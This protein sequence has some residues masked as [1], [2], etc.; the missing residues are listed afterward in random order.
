MRT[1]LLAAVLSAAA[2][3]SLAGR[4]TVDPNTGPAQEARAQAPDERLDQKVTCRVGRARL[5]VLLEDITRQTGVVVRAG[6]HPG[7]WQVRDIPMVVYVADVPLGRLLRAV[8]DASHCTL[9]SE[10]VENDAKT[11]TYRILRPAAARNEIAAAVEQ[12]R[13]AQ[14]AALKWEWDALVRIAGLPEQQLA[15]GVKPEAM[16]LLLE[17]AALAA[18]LAPDIRQRVFSGEVVRLDGLESPQ[19]RDWFIRQQHRRLDSVPHSDTPGRAAHRQDLKNVDDAETLT[20]TMFL[21]DDDAGEPRV[22]GCVRA[23]FAGGYDESYDLYLFGR[24]REIKDAGA[25]GLAPKPRREDFVKS[26]DES[27]G[28]DYRPLSYGADFD[29]P[30]LNVKVKPEAEPQPEEITVCDRLAALAEAGGVNIICEDFESHKQASYGPAGAFFGRDTTP[31]DELKALGDRMRWFFDE[32]HRLVLGWAR[33]WQHKHTDLVAADR[34]DYLHGRLHGSGVALE[35]LMA[36]RDLTPNQVREWIDLSRDLQPL[37][38]KRFGRDTFPLWDL[39]RSLTPQDR[40]LCEAN[41]GLPLGS[42]DPLWLESF[43]ASS[44]AS[45][46]RSGIVEGSPAWYNPAFPGDIRELMEYRLRVRPDCGEVFQRGTPDSDAAGEKSRCGVVMVLEKHGQTLT[47]SS[48]AG[49]L[50]VLARDSGASGAVRVQTLT[51]KEL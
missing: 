32:R 41:E 47:F 42:F 40:A 28:P 46:A 33:D 6:A 19:V 17:R 10:S 22:H 21:E 48:V 9:R 4:I 29:I 15:A 37:R 12:K 51:V 30:G 43:L 38:G 13:N 16:G 25:L 18:S 39:Y 3:T 50:P 49:A 5:H 44:S 11:L 36:L 20:L 24:L 14:L 34:L 8:A 27:P 31:A 23:S 1:L 26:G 7:D 45:A 2:N 35:D